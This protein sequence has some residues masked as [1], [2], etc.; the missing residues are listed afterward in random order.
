MANFDLASSFIRQPASQTLH[1]QT[2]NRPQAFGRLPETLFG[3]PQQFF[4]DY[5]RQ[6]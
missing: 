5:W 3:Q 6:I 4:S 2:G 1:G